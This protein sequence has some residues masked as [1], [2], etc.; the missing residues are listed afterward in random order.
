MGSL[1]GIP[2]RSIQGSA[3]LTETG[4]RVELGRRAVQAVAEWWLL[5]F[6]R[7]PSDPA[8]RRDTDEETPMT[9]AIGV[10]RL[11]PDCD[12]LTESP[13][14]SQCGRSHTVPLTAWVRPL[15]AV[16]SP[17]SVSERTQRQANPLRELTSDR[18]TERPPG[19]GTDRLPERTRR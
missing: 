8:Q 14:C 12:I 7:R 16:S 13:I 5:Q 9:L 17:Q 15:D 6:E 11:C 1:S 3:G 18:T 10:A 2:P 4:E 19:Y